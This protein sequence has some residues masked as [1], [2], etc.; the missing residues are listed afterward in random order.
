MGYLDG[1]LG[2][3]LLGSSA[4]WKAICPPLR[5]SVY[6]RDSFGRNNL[7][8]EVLGEFCAAASGR[9]DAMPTQDLLLKSSTGGRQVSG[10]Y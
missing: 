10:S 9:G 5:R 8:V 6:R 3:A 4:P 1:V 7:F 2:D